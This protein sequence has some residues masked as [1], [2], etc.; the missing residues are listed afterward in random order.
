M[1]VQ[2]K[3]LRVVEETLEDSMDAI[4]TEGESEVTYC[5]EIDSDILD[6]IETEY[7]NSTDIPK[8]KEINELFAKDSIDIA[9]LRYAY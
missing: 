2:I 9:I 7:P 5:G 8:L 3:T 4:A 6:Y 1:T